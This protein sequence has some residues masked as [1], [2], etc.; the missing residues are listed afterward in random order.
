[1]TFQEF[2]EAYEEDYDTAKREALVAKLLAATTDV[3]TLRTDDGTSALGWAIDNYASELAIAL[4]ERNVALDEPVNSPPFAGSTSR[5]RL[6]PLYAASVKRLVRLVHV[7][8]AKGADAGEHA[9]RIVTNLLENRTLIDEEHSALT[10]V[11]RRLVKDAN[12]APH[13]RPL[14][15][16]A[17][18]IVGARTLLELGADP[19]IVSKYEYD[20]GMTPLHQAAAKGYDGVVDV[21]LAAGARKDALDRNKKTPAMLAMKERHVLIAAKLDPS[22]SGKLFAVVEKKRLGGRA[23]PAELKAL[24]NGALAGDTAVLDAVGELS[25]VSGDDELDEDAESLGVPKKLKSKLWWW[26]R[27]A[28]GALV[29]FFAEKAAPLEGSVIMI[30]NEGQVRGYGRTI[31]EFL[32]MRAEEVESSA[33]VKEWLEKHGLLPARS[34]EQIVASVE[35]QPLPKI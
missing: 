1:M 8:L 4:V 35:T 5:E 31:S 29:G 6:A 15:C 13:G 30:D 32:V 3:S 33:L 21:L 22:L 2:I 28:D 17:A 27:E 16:T 34:L 24:W 20:D 19:N 11:L 12:K 7:M 23:M 14:L 9:D 26:A 25:L 18:N 10:D